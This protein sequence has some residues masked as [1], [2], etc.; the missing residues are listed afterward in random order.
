MPS[1]MMFFCTP[2]KAYMLTDACRT[3][4]SRPMGKTPGGVNARPQ[5]CEQCTLAS[6]V[7]A[8]KVPT[9]TLA[10]FLDGRMPA[11]EGN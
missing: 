8:R 2:Q 1:P 4:R 5:V 10:A 3:L 7:D 11:A 9:V 6:R